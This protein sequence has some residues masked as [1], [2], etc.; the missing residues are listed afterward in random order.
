[1]RRQAGQPTCITAI[2]GWAGFRFFRFAVEGYTGLCEVADHTFV[3]RVLGRFV[4]RLSRAGAV[5]GTAAADQGQAQTQ[6]E[7]ESKLHVRVRTAQSLRTA[8]CAPKCY[9]GPLL[10][11][12]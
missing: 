2:T 9:S 8:T 4:E 10:Q 6:R 5:G 3:A 1:M 12:R 7:L 11:C